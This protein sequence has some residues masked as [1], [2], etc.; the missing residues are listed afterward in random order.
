MCHLEDLL[1]LISNGKMVA[2]ESYDGLFKAAG[3]EEVATVTV[4]ENAQ[5]DWTEEEERLAKRK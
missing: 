4:V 2:Q 3:D 1:Q 5:P